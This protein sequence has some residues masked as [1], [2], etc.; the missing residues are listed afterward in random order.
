MSQHIGVDAVW[1]CLLPWWQNLGIVVHLN[2]GMFREVEAKSRD[3]V[4]GRQI[5]ED[6]LWLCCLCG[7][8]IDVFSGDL[9]DGQ[10]RVK[11]TEQ[12]LR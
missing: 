3:Q 9:D 12:W 4:E 8:R 7:G 2:E 6:L 1:P 10:F 11:K 5:Y